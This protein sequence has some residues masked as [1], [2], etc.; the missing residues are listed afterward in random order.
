VSSRTLLLITVLLTLLSVSLLSG[1]VSANGST[2]RIEEL[3]AASAAFAAATTSAAEYLAAN[4]T[5]YADWQR[6]NMAR[7]FIQG[8]RFQT[9]ASQPS[10]QFAWR[11]VPALTRLAC[12]PLQEHESLRIAAAPVASI[13]TGLSGLAEQPKQ[14]GIGLLLA[15]ITYDPASRAS[16]SQPE[17][18]TDTLIA[19][20]EKDLMEAEIQLASGSGPESLEAGLAA[21]ATSIT[22]IL[23]L[24]ALLDEGMGALG[25]LVHDAKQ[26][27]AIR[28]YVQSTAEDVASA[29][30]GAESLLARKNRIARMVAAR[31]IVLGYGAFWASSGAALARIEQKLSASNV[32]DLA[33]K[34]NTL[35]ASADQ[36]R[37]RL[38]D[39]ASAELAKIES[40]WALASAGAADARNAVLD[41]ELVKIA[42]VWSIFLKLCAQY[43]AAAVPA[44]LAAIMA[45]KREHQKLVA[46]VNAKGTLADVTGRL[47]AI[48]GILESLAKIQE[49][50]KTE[51]NADD[52]G[53]S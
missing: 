50:L 17:R 48:Q 49:E 6:K 7:R 3:R 42:D 41:P 47:K 32:R 38:K 1:T 40:Q 2:K 43:D 25:Q 26:E 31:D 39:P 23:K 22:S 46:D 9:S 51:P 52:K 13:A 21:T 24:V 15:S 16:S 18:K 8:V 36:L 30:H 53:K 5:D 20:C 10:A 12:T 19:D 11:K 35:A 45:L 14:S 34:E 28:K 33:A 37:A 29:I 44:N 27:S 4:S